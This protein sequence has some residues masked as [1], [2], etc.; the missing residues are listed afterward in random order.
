MQILYTLYIKIMAIG[1]FEK[2]G[3]YNDANFIAA[4]RLR[5]VYQIDG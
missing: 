3:Q 4:L 5:L 1:N 2:L